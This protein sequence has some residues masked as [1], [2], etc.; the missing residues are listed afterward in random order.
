MYACQRQ[1]Q[2]RKSYEDKQCILLLWCVL[3]LVWPSATVSKMIPPSVFPLVSSECSHTKPESHTQRSDC[4]QTAA[5]GALTTGAVGSSPA[6][7]TLAGVGGRTTAMNAAL[8]T[9]SWTRR[10]QEDW[11]QY[12]TRCMICIRIS[13][14]GVKK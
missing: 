13:H 2:K 7:F 12:S 10:R 8:C 4:S 9:M 3:L 1:K 11:D 14:I 5:A 6:W